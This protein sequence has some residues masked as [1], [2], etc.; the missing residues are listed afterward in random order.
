M[1]EIQE[2]GR[3][4]EYEKSAELKGRSRS[5]DGAREFQEQG[6]FRSKGV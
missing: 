3:I 2:R 6:S 5:L 1:K 4:R